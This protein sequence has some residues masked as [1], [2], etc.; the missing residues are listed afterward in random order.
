MS[1]GRMTFK[2]DTDTGNTRTEP[3]SRRP[4]S[5]LGTA[6]DYA[7]AGQRREVELLQ[8]RYPADTGIES[9]RKEVSKEPE[10]YDP[11]LLYREDQE[12]KIST[13]EDTRQFFFHSDHPPDLWD[14]PPRYPHAPA[15]DYRDWPEERSHG[16]EWPAEYG[17]YED[18]P[19]RG[20]SYGGSYHTRRPSHWWKLALSIA[21]A[22]G[23]GILLGYAA[24]SLI[25]GGRIAGGNNTSSVTSPAVQSVTDTGAVLP[26]DAGVNAGMNRI[27]VKVAAQTY[28]LLQYGVFS[29]PA[30]AEQARQELLAAGLAA[31]LDPADGNRVY[32]G[33]SPDREQAK[34]LS[35]GL[36]NQGIELYV[37]E[38]SLP[39]AEQ[40]AFAGSA[41][42]IDSYFAASGKLLGELSRLSASELS[43]P[44]EAVDTTEV[45]NLHMQWNEAVKAMEP[46]L[47][48]AAQKLCA[49]LEKS[50]SRGISA[51][52]EYNKNQAQA[53]LW[54][55][56]E[57][58]MSFLTTQKSLLSALS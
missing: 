46:G 21:G 48:A 32:A 4:G 29:T 35:S 42:T 33:M 25:G 50:M 41:E 16:P 26:P 51:L 28:Y 38:L 44:G 34:L 20:G 47:P 11:A 58:M 27:P 5:G 49:S 37:R 12:D 10:E 57:A 56:Q 30:G 13:R 31:G 6:R 23:T 52:N 24:L 18:N 19:L 55:V 39:A 8:Q 43:G 54:E 3:L 2:F 22:L 15:E 17:H 53:L 40:A 7:E 36:K 14:Q 9:P 45:S 1:N